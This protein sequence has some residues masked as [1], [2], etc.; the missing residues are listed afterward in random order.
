MENKIIKVFLLHFAGGS[1]YSFDFLRPFLPNCFEFIPLEL[2][3]RGKR[4]G[5]ALIKN[6][7]IAVEDYVK[8]IKLLHEGVPFII[9]GHSMGADLGF[10]VTKKLEKS[11]LF[12]EYLFVSGNPGPKKE[13]Y[14]SVKE[15]SKKLRYKLSDDELKEELREIGGMPEEV[16]QDNDIFD[17]FKPIIRADFQVLEDD[18]TLSKN[19]VIKSPI[20][21][22]MGEKEEH[23]SRIDNWKNYTYSSFNCSLFKGNHFFIY[24]HP[25]SIS[26]IIKEALTSNFN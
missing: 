9:F 7:E 11:L 8:Q 19:I 10:Y 5:Q 15:K 13:T 25:E 21:A 18:N 2:P 23:S 14:D 22:L 20:Y 24:D 3:G 4:I 6:K 17:F 26:V 12:P 16:L 1:S